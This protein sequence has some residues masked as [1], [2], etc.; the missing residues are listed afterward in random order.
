[1]PDSRKPQLEYS[2]TQA[3]MLD[4]ESRRAKAAKIAAVVKHFLGVGDLTGLRVVDCGCSGGIIADELHAAGATVIGLDIDVPGVRKA[5]ERFGQTVS[6][7]CAD[8]ERIP[9]AT[10]SADVVICNHIYEHVVDPVRLFAELQRVVRP[11]GVLYLGLGNK[12]GIIEPHYRLPFLSWL[13]RGLA[14]RYVRATGRAE[15]YYEQF[16]TW[17]GLRRL[18]AG[19]HVWDY[20]FSV[21]AEPGRFAA[22]DAVPGWAAK[23][24]PALLRAARPV[25]PTYI[26]IATPGQAHPRGAALA[27]PP[28]A[29]P[30]AHRAAAG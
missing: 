9:L 8:S 24:P 23:V 4:E 12:L 11:D 29:V 3:L 28:V 15:S 30:V 10:G 7:I 13:P 22:G 27:V 16:T 14:H 21:L 1:V 5:H 20:T 25:V 17:S 26:W 2:E 19:L 6:F 18:A